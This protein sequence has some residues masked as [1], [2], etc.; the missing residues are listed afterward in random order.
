MVMDAR[1]FWRHV[2]MSP[3][4]ARAAFAP[5]VRE[6]IARAIAEGERGHRG[7]IRFAVE[8]ELGTLALLRGQSPR[9]RAIEVFRR[10]GI[11]RTA[12]ATGVLIY[13]L[14]ADRCVEIVADRGVAATVEP[15]QW[16]AVCQAMQR[17]FGEGRFE[18]GAVDGVRS[19]SELLARHFPAQGGNDN[20]LPDK[21]VML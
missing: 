10:L 16:E 19:V 11:D 13:V 6:A 18:A 7:E 8:A 9:A 17:A 5:H 2:V 3:R 1:R 12:E 20:E 14:L 15:A 21:P 4:R